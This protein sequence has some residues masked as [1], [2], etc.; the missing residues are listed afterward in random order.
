MSTFADLMKFKGF[1]FFIILIFGF[2]C[3][4]TFAQETIFEANRAIANVKKEIKKEKELEQK[5]AKRSREFHKNSDKKLSAI[6]KQIKLT[7]QLNDSLKSE[8]KKLRFA[9]SKVKNRAKYFKIKKNKFSGFLVTQIDT[10]ILFVEKDFPFEKESKLESLNE[11]KGLLKREEITVDDAMIR[12]W[13]FVL[14]LFKIGYS[15]EVY[16]GELVEPG[17]LKPIK[18]KFLRFGAVF[19]AF[20]SEDG[21]QIK[22]LRKDNENYNWHHLNQNIQLRQQ[23][24]TAFKIA[25]GK[26]APELI[27]IPIW[28]KDLWGKDL[29]NKE[30]KDVG[31]ENEGVK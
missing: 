27:H 1:W 21:A 8:I 3:Q 10:L 15:S 19:M 11:L 30:N 23:I 17:N 29:S 22:L 12:I 20:L 4:N 26:K 5:E 18:G 24:K 16:L 2:Y 6:R 31:S 28:S 13:S 25:D 7:K 9:K 14:N